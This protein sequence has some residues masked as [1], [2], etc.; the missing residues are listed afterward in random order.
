LKDSVLANFDLMQNMNSSKRCRQGKSTVFV[1]CAILALPY[2]MACQSEYP[3]PH[4]ASARKIN[5]ILISST[6]VA[7]RIWS[8]NVTNLNVMAFGNKVMLFGIL[9]PFPYQCESLS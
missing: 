5:P 3:W 6:I 7:P 1:A 2:F 9:L 4:V 8:S